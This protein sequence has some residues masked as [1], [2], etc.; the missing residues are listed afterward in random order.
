MQSRKLAIYL[1][2]PEN[3]G[4]KKKKQKVCLCQQMARLSIPTWVRVIF[5]PVDA[6]EETLFATVTTIDQEKRREKA[7]KDLAMLKTI[8]DNG[9]VFQLP[10]VKDLLQEATDYGSF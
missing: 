1:I 5:I 10:Y 4:K 8:C 7:L 2:D 3:F 6:I 9:K